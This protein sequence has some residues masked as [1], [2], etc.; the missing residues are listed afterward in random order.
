MQKYDKYKNLLRF[1]LYFS[2]LI[3]I[4]RKNYQV[5]KQTLEEFY[6]KVEMTQD[7]IGRM[8]HACYCLGVNI[9]R[10]RW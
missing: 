1:L 7:L 4:L 10:G 8:W 2:K 3:I 6:L 9:V 5:S